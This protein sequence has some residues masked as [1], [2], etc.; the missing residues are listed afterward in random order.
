[1][2]VMTCDDY[3]PLRRAPTS[4]RTAP[5][6]VL[7]LLLSLAVTLPSASSFLFPTTAT[8]RSKASCWKTRAESSDA[9]EPVPEEDDPF[10]EEDNND[11]QPRSAGGLTLEGV[12][13]RL[14]LETQGLDDGIVGLESKDTEFGVSPSSCAQAGRPA[15]LGFLLHCSLPWK[16][17]GGI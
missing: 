17:Y 12:Y 9:V 7:L 1:M 16:E 6:Y 11:G 3:T 2:T 5:S 14:K 10:A 8:V 13:R 4:S 15:V